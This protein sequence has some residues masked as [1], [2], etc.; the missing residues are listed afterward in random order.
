MDIE[1]YL[2]H[3]FP[4]REFSD[5][6][7][8]LAD[9]LLNPV[10]SQKRSLLPSRFVSVGEEFVHEG[11]RY[12]CRERPRCHPSEACSGCDIARLYRGCGSLQCSAFDRRDGKDVWFSDVDE[13]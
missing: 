6:E 9:A 1:S 3:L 13:S 12:V 5:R 8:E 4:G 2:S 11:H 7:L 10:S